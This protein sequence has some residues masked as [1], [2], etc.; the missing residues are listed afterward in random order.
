MPATASACFRKSVS[1]LLFAL[2]FPVCGCAPALSPSAAGI[3][4]AGKE[5][6]SGCRYLG[7]V[8]GTSKVGSQVSLAT[9]AGK[10]RA[11]QEAL[12]KAARL[13]GTHVV[14]RPIVDGYPAFAIGD[15]YSCGETAR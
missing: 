4:E 15:V 11:R 8:T 5:A 6:V 13:G 3:R 10:D 12:E 1:G 2:L 7:E 9:H 14:W